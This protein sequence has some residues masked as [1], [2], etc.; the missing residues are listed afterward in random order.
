MSEA[1]T[2][3]ASDRLGGG[4]GSARRGLRRGAAVVDF[5]AVLRGSRTTAASEGG[6]DL[7]GPASTV[8]VRLPRSVVLPLPAARTRRGLTDVLRPLAVSRAL[9]HG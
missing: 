5:E 8:A 7:A 1:D 9:I 6:D 2:R 3:V 4:I